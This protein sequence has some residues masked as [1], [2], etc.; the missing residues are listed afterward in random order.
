MRSGIVVNSKTAVT[1][2][3]YILP[4][5]PIPLQRPRFIKG[6]VFDP[7]SSEKMHLRTY[8]RFLLPKNHLI[9]EGPVELYI[10][11]FMKQSKKSTA[12][13]HIT[14]PDLSN[15]VK[16][17]EDLCTGILYVDDRQITKIIADK[18]YDK[19]PRTEFYLVEVT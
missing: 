1:N 3:I 7:Q 16:F 15:M 13:E 9:V 6:H 18:K 17:Y 2:K 8:L 14:V 4:G 5:K 11:F 19:N 12:I 10:T